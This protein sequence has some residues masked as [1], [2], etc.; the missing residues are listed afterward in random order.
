MTQSLVQLEQKDKALPFWEK[1]VSI[2]QFEE[3][4]RYAQFN[5]MQYAFEVKNMEL[6]TRY[7]EE[8]LALSKLEER[9]KWDAYY[10]LAK[11]SQERKIFLKLL[12]PSS[13]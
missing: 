6:A 3:N 12:R 11:A 2:A 5:L 1:L 7:A 10:I 4:K 9:V 8:I 13:N